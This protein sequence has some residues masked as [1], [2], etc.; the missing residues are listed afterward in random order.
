VIIGKQWLQDLRDDLHDAT[1]DCPF[2][3][4]LRARFDDLVSAWAFAERCRWYAIHGISGPVHNL[5][6]DQEILDA[7]NAT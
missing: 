7:F 2:R 3:G 6:S 4:S 1:A 5:P